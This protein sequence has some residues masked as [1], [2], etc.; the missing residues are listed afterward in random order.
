MKD[1]DLRD[2]VP[3]ATPLGAS[4]RSEPS[5]DG[6]TDSLVGRRLSDRY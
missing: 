2:L 6:G 4:F 5:L 3:G 1:D